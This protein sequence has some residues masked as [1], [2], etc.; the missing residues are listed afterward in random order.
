[1]KHF[2]ITL[3]D[4]P[5]SVQVAERCVKSAAKFNIMVEKF[6]AITPQSI[7][8]LMECKQIPIDGFNNNMFSRKESM[9]AA[10]MSHY[11]L[12]EY[13][14]INNTEVTIFEHDA[15]IFDNI[16]SVLMYNGCINFGR[17]SYGQWQTP[18]FLG[19]NPLTSKRYFPGAHAYRVNPRGASLLVQQAKKSAGP[20]DVFLNLNS[21]PWLEEYY[22]WPVIADDYFTTIQNT[23][24]CLAKHNYNERYEI[25]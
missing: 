1:M 4:N 17:P 18:N 21:F 11:L 5:K 2:V 7:Y 25:I 9:M 16:P 12:W 22:P 20:T 6:E 24:G 3:V 14:I 23:T 13:S 8:L 10:F 19:V 15:V